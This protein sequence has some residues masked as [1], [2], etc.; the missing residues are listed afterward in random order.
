MEHFVPCQ[1]KWNKSFYYIAMRDKDIP[2]N[3]FAERLKELRLEAGL[4]RQELANQ[5]N[6]SVRLLSYWENDQRE[7]NFDALIALSVILD[8]SIDYL[9]GKSDF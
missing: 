1:E 8:T 5:L 3:K 4:T 2:K 9:L 6:I 7:C